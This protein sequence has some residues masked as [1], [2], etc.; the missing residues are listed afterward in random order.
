MRKGFLF[1]AIAG[2]APIAVAGIRL[3]VASDRSDAVYR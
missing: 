2:L 1:G 3:E